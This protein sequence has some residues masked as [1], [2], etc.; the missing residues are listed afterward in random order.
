VRLW[1][2]EKSKVGIGNLDRKRNDWIELSL[3]Y[4]GMGEE[5]GLVDREDG[6]KM[7]FAF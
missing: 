1:V 6:V 5:E 4:S 3:H 2:R 7:T